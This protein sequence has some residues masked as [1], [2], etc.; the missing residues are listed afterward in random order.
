MFLKTYDALLSDT[1]IK[2]FADFASSKICRRYAYSSRNNIQT[3]SRNK[4]EIIDDLLNIANMK[5]YRTSIIDNK[6]IMIVIII[7]I[8]K[9]N[10][11]QSKLMY[12]AGIEK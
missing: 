7:E 2:N 8:T 1:K 3:N 4:N 10:S 12:C 9:N 6:K 5:I 11:D